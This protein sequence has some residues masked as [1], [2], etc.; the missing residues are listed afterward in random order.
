MLKSSYAGK[1]QHSA[2]Q[3]KVVSSRLGTEALGPP[4]TQSQRVVLRCVWQEKGQQ[5]KAT[6]VLLPTF[7][8][9]RCNSTDILYV[10]AT[11]AQLRCTHRAKLLGALDKVFSAADADG[12]PLLCLVLREQRRLAALRLP[13]ELH[14]N[15]NISSPKL[16]ISWTIPAVSAAP[17]SVTRTGYA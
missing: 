9:Y 13:H 4:S 17:V 6:E 14:Q 15:A 8:P 2:W 16:E 12:V 3:V 5:A 1:M 7:T 10:V 11:I